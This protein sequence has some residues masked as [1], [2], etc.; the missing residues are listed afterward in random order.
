MTYPITDEKDTAHFLV[1]FFFFIL[2]YYYTHTQACTH[3]HTHLHTHTHAQTHTCRFFHESKTVSLLDC[4]QV[5]DSIV[6][7]RTQGEERGRE[8]LYSSV[9]QRK[10]VM[11][12]CR[13][14]Q[15]NKILGNRVF[16][17][18]SLVL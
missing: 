1:F 10:G 5:S 17:L 15:R 12:C 14:S 6:I 11:K 4:C 13:K 9:L 2:P 16:L 8:I 3:R 18:N 7:N